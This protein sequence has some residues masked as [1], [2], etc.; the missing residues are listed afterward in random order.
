[1]AVFALHMGATLAATHMRTGFYLFTIPIVVPQ[2]LA[3]GTTK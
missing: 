1:M 2:T 3:M